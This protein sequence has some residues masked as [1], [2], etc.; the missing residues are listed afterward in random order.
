MRHVLLGRRGMALAV[1]GFCKGR[2]VVNN[3]LHENAKL[4]T[5]IDEVDVINCALQ[6]RAEERT[7]RT[8][9]RPIWQR[10]E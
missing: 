6:E 2:D 9:V 5:D 3:V 1:A 10:Q 7:R 8:R 4:A